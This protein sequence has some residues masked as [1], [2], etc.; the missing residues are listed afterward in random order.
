[1]SRGMMWSKIETLTVSNTPTT[2]ITEILS[3]PN[4]S[5]NNYQVAV[6]TL[7]VIVD[8]IVN[9]TLDIIPETLENSHAF[10]LAF[11][12]FIVYILVCALDS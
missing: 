4:K 10:Q 3:S 9:H 8:V 12:F 5:R 7:A 1:M 2:E 11:S 6:K